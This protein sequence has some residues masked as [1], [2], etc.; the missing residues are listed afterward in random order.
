MPELDGLQATRRILAAND[1]ARIL[2]T[3]RR[4]TW[5]NTS[6]GSRRFAMIQP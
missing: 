1:L 3:P 6:G 2:I 5:T 4:L